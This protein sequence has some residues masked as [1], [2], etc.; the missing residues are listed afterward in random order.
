MLRW[1]ASSLCSV[2][3]L[4]ELR[5]AHEEFQVVIDAAIA[6]KSR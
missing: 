3:R 6:R 4:R 1:L 2:E 5:E